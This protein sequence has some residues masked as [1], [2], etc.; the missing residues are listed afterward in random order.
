MNQTIPRNTLAYRV[1]RLPLPTACH[2]CAEHRSALLGSVLSLSHNVRGAKVPRQGLRRT[3]DTVRRVRPDNAIMRRVSTSA[4]PLLRA[5]G[6]MQPVR[7]LPGRRALSLSCEES[8]P[9]PV[10]QVGNASDPASLW[11]RE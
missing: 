3:V 11:S 2:A 6:P 5:G 9:G 10:S 4:N 8:P 7:L 1:L